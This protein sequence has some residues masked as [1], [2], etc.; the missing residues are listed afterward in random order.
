MHPGAL[1]ALEFDR[2]VEAVGNL[3]LTPLGRTR[4][5]DLHPQTQP[6]QVETALALTTEATRFLGEDGSFPLRAPEDLEALLVVLAVEGRPLEPGSLMGLAGFLS[7]VEHVR[8]GVQR[9]AAEFPLLRAIVESASSFEREI[10][11]IQ[12]KI[13]PAGTLADDASPDLRAIRDR[14]RKGRQ[15]LRGLLE[16]F[17]RGR[18]TARHLQ[19]QVVTDRNGRYVLVVKTE[20]RSAIPGIVHGSSS[21]GA[22]LFLEP[23]STVEVNNELVAL[24]E[25]ETEEVRRI[26]LALTD[27]F[28]RRAAD[29]QRTLD[30]ATELDVA[31]A[32]GRFSQITGA[33]APLLSSDGRLEL[34]GARHPLL[35][36]AVVALL[37]GTAEPARVP[38]AGPVPVDIRIV[39]P[40]SVLVI[41]GPNTGGKTVALKAAGLLAAMAQAGL[42]VPAE[43]GSR[44]PVFRSI[45]ADIGDEQ[46]IAASLSTFSWHMTNVAAMD[47]TL[48]LPA[49]VLLDEVGAGTDPVEGGALGRALIEHFR[50]RGALVVATTH[51]DTLKSYA[52][53]GEGVS[54]AAFG[55]DPETFAPTYRLIYGAPGRSLALEIAARLGLPAAVIDTAR[56]Y[57]SAREAQLAEHL[58]R[59]DQDMN[60]LEHDRRLVL[61]ERETL[62]AEAARLGARQEE[63]RGREA[64]FRRRLDEQIDQRVREARREIDAIIEGLKRRTAALGRDASRQASAAPLSTG[65]VGA[66]RADARSAVERVAQQVREVAAGGAGAAAAG[67]PAEGGPAGP[68][69]GA[70]DR[71][72][73]GGLG[74]E[75]TVQAVHGREAEVEVRGKRLRVRLDD[76]RVLGA[77]RATP[78]VSVSVNLQPREGSLT[79]LNVIGCTVDEALSRADRF[80]DAALASELRMVRLIHGHGTGQL[81]RALA[82]FLQEHPLVERFA[83]A[84]PEQGGGGVTVVELKE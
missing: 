48:Q 28:R 14:L 76:L 64:A 75:G 11:E 82:S 31:Q 53:T 68:G 65:E 13:E 47:R 73:V 60:S 50:R 8:D 51:Y 83:A 43:A 66:A 21:S 56:E 20:H 34:V 15:R 22:S 57:R 61:R 19:E 32:K 36:P 59:L 41:T 33:A 5:R 25:Q 24:E 58:A 63:L 3:A 39:P 26:L 40:A 1:R 45:F 6:R 80:L 23:L 54:S 16:S 77:A 10:G 49:L 2:V 71:V 12:R 7:S 62:A 84:S 4:L 79:D 78:G 52:S 70:G 46:S 35:M 72:L 37:P 18:E 38:A 69:A 9:V 30:A 42:H 27:A 17:L 74:L 55:F 67:S 44:L 81:R 29:L